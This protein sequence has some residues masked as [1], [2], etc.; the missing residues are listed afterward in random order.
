[1]RP[2]LSGEGAGL[3]LEAGDGTGA[4]MA[5]LLRPRSIVIVGAS[6]GSRWSQTAYD[7]LTRS[8]FGGAVH[9]VNRR[10]GAVHGQPAATSSTAIGADLD[11]GIVIV[12][13]SAVAAAIDDLGAAGARA[14]VVLTSGFAETGQAGAALQAEFTASARRHGIRLLGPNS[15]GFINF[16]GNVQAWTTPVR[17]PSRKAGVAIVSQ[18]GATAFFL[19]ELGYQQDLGLSYVIATGNEA[20]LDASAFVDFLIDD[21]DTRAIALFVET[22]RDPA[23]FLKAAGRAL[24]ARKPI[25]VLKVGASEVTAKSAA[26]HT[27]A[28]VGDDRVFDGICRQFG[29]IRVRSIEALLAT[30]D[31]AARTGVLREG[32]LC[33]VSN[34]GGICEIAADTAQARGIRVPELQAA[35]ATQLRESMPGFGTPHNPLDLTGGI[36]PAQ[37]EQAVRLLGEQPEYAAI[38]CAWYAIPTCREEESPRLAQLHHH[39][40]NGL[41]A[42][43][44]P[45]L[46]ASYTHNQVND[47][48]RAIVEQTRAPYSAFGLDRAITGLAGVFWWSERQRRSGTAL[49]DSGAAG[50]VAERPSSERAALEFLSRHG[51]PVVPATLATVETE[52]VAAA[53]AIGGPVVLKIASPDIAHKSDIGGVALNLEGERAVDA[54]FRRI[55]EASRAR[56]P[57]ARIDGVLVSP[58][59]ERGIELL[60]GLSRDP[61]WGPVLAVGLGGIWVEVLEDVSLRVLPVDAGEIRRMLTELR[62]AKLLAGERGVPAAD[63]DAVAVVIERIATAALRLGPE[64]AAMDVNPLWVRGERVEALD[65]LFVW[66]GTEA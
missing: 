4:A 63:L 26:A 42:V 43:P 31:I 20:D 47:H 40:S 49:P 65:A 6:E 11:L 38:L 39:L 59:R 12:P 51:V 52:A 30:A 46:L 64:L 8:G 57:E 60:V 2:T 48:A 54:A 55:M 33:I 34:S 58:M 37:C 25:V 27:G 17:A 56:A 10:G 53:K 16:A 41:N 29:I 50:I 1:M 13:A 24:R 32:G 15:L 62:G 45:G 3:S 61:Q 14:A 23:R 19:A 44:I 35:V 7:N 9:L 18:S 28:L 66:H 5:A 21:P 22:V 36:E